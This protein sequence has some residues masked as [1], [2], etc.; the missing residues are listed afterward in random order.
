VPEEKSLVED[1]QRQMELRQFSFTGPAGLLLGVP[2]LQGGSPAYAIAGAAVAVLPYA[3]RLLPY[4]F[5]LFMHLQGKPVTVED[6]GVKITSDG[7][8]VDQ[9][10]VRHAGARRA[11]VRAIHP[12]QGVSDAQDH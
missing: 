9:T 2:T 3:F 6:H 4:G 11:R 8:D 10:P 1:G 7:R 5:F 12:D